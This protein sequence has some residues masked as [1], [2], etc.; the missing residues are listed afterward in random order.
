MVLSSVVYRVEKSSHQIIKIVQIEGDWYMKV[1]LSNAENG[2]Y[3]D[4]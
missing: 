1:W 4:Y 3:I 2:R